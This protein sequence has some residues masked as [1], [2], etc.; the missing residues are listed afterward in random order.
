MLAKPHGP[1]KRLWMSFTSMQR[2][3]TEWKCIS[4]FFSNIC[5]PG[6]RWFKRLRTGYG[7]FQQRK[8]FEIRLWFSANEEAAVCSIKLW[9]SQSV[10]WGCTCKATPSWPNSLHSAGSEQ[11]SQSANDFVIEES[12]FEPGYNWCHWKITVL[13]PVLET[14]GQCQLWWLLSQI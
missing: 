11:I 14:T 7:R 13:I 6:L 12:E 10:L 3:H 2:K 1:V 4:L 8:A 9:L 5:A